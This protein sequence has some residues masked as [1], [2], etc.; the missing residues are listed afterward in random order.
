MEKAGLV[1]H[2]K[3]GQTH[4]YRPAVSREEATGNLLGDFL[5]RFFHGSA[6][7]LVLGLVD[8]RQLDPDAL[9]AIEARLA[10]RSAEAPKGR[11]KP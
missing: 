11:K 7:Q 4:R 10:D 6:E 2:E 5:S 8:S 1:A 3:E 9:R